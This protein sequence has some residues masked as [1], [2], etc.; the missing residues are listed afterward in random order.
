MDKYRPLTEWLKTQLFD[1][2]EVTLDDI[3]DQ[4]KIGVELPRA[5]REHPVWWANELNP[6]TRHY[7]CRAWTDTGFSAI[8]ISFS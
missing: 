3:E 4:D 2:V 5:T 6:K 1:R 8:C 7:Q